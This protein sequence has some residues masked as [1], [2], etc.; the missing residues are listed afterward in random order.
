[1]LVRHVLAFRPLLPPGGA[2]HGVFSTVWREHPRGLTIEAAP[3]VSHSQGIVG[4][5]VQ[6]E[7]ANAAHWPSPMCAPMPALQPCCTVR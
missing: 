5:G 7:D 2:D 1:M 6:Q 4:N 3:V